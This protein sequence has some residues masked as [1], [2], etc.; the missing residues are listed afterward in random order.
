MAHRVQDAGVEQDGAES[1]ETTGQDIG[2]GDHLPT[3]D[4]VEEVPDGERAD[5]IP[6]GEED[7]VVGGVRGRDVVDLGEDQRVE[8]K[9]MAL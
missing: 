2:T 6:Q 3:P 4:S 1:E 7:E 9:K 5:E 8:V